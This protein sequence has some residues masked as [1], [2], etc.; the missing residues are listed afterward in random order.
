[1]PAAWFSEPLS[2]ELTQTMDG[3]D[4]RGLIGK[5]SFTVHS[6]TVRG[7]RV[8]MA[9]LTRGRYLILTG[10]IA[11]G[12]MQGEVVWAGQRETWSARLQSADFQ[13]S[14]PRKP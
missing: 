13:S 8:R 6:A 4:G 9:L 12:R 2:I 11:N 5:D 1:L 10:S 7:E 3:V 14:L